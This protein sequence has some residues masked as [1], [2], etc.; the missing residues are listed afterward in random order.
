MPLPILNQSFTNL[1]LLLPC[2]GFL[3]NSI[4][5]ETECGTK[6]ILEMLTTDYTTEE[7]IFV[8]CKKT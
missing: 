3:L 8:E 2:V 6:A 7:N 5:P 1:T 4:Q